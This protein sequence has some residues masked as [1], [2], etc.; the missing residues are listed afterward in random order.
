MGAQNEMS[1]ALEKLLL[2]SS[3]RPGLPAVAGAESTLNI[4]VVFTSMRSTLAALKEAGSLATRLSAQVTLIVPQVV[5]YPLPI[6]SPPVL[7]DFSERRFRAIATNSAVRTMVR[8]Y[9]C[10]DAVETLKAVLSPRSLVV[11]GGRRRW[12]PT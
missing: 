11:L 3:G 1:L 5:P 7:V 9:L 10:R 8:L 6:E 2:P 12:W 4:A